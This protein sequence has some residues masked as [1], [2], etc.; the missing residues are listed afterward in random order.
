MRLLVVAHNTDPELIR[1]ALGRFAAHPAVELLHLADG[2]HSPAGPR[3]YAL[4]HATAPYFAF[5]DSDDAL[6]PGALDSWLALAQDAAAQVVLARIERGDT[7]DPD[8]LPPTRPARERALHPVLDRLV[9]RSEPVGLIARGR[10]PGLRFSPG[11]ESGEDLAVSAELWFS[12]AEIA[13][14]RTGPAY[15]FGDDAADRVTARRRTLTADFAFLDA[16]ANA[17]WFRGL[18][19]SARRAFGVKVFRLH[20]FDAVLARLH[21]DGVHGGLDAHRAAFAE[22]AQ[23]IERLAPGSLALL[24]RRDRAAIREAASPTSTPESIL[25]LLEARWLGGVDSILT[26]NPFLALHRQG[27]RRTLRDMVA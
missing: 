2:I 5:L 9:Y 20:Y 24:S 16:I 22:L 27:P 4:D 21:D 1:I 12:G 15:I 14:D 19:R 3:N 7:R 17:E 25:A 13:Y 18:K 8:P 26:Q 10:F 6:A 23:R 11:L